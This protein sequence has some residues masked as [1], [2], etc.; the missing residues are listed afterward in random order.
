MWPTATTTDSAGARTFDADGNRIRAN[1]GATLTDASQM[2]PTPMAGTPAQNGNSAAGNN[3]FSR[4]ADALGRNVMAQA[5]Q[6]TTPQAHDVT[7]RGNGQVPT[8][9]AGNRCLAR[10]ADGFTRPDPAIW[11]DGA[12]SCRT[13]QR[14]RQLYRLA[15]STVSR[16]TLRRWSKRDAWTKRR[17]NPVF[18]EWLM[19]WPPGHALCGCS[20]TEFTRW[21]RDMRGALSALP[22]ASASWIW[23]PQE[24][25]QSEQLD[26]FGN[27]L[28]NEEP[29][30]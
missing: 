5:A 23:T 16:A 13:I 15:M 20:A 9:A 21:Q 6:W 4:A 11:P 17:L 26:L 18:V 12:M 22:L 29:D 19:G 24:S 27:V 10:D 2:W 7:M 28:N 1:A 30:A 3:D 25:R 8:A 14:G